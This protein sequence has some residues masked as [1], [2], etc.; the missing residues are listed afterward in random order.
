MTYNQRRRYA[1][2]TI[3][4]AELPNPNPNPNPSS[5][6]R[7]DKYETPGN[8]DASNT[9]AINNVNITSTSI[10]AA[11]N[12]NSTITNPSADR[13]SNPP[14][15]NSNPPPPPPSPNPNPNPNPNPTS[16]EK[17]IVQATR[18][19]L[20][21]VIDSV[22]LALSKR[23]RDEKGG[24]RV[25]VE[26]N[27]DDGLDNNS[28]G[29]GRDSRGKSGV[30]EF[31]NEAEE[32]FILTFEDANGKDLIYFNIVEQGDN[33][34]AKPKEVVVAFKSV[35]VATEYVE[36]LRQK[37][38]GESFPNNGKIKSLPPKTLLKI[39]QQNG[40]FVTLEE[41]I[42]GE[43]P[44]LV[45]PPRRPNTLANRLKAIWNEK[46]PERRL[47]LISLEGVHPDDVRASV[48]AIVI[49]PPKSGNGRR[50]RRPKWRGGS[51]D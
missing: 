39:C 28:D 9:N 1:S 21:S 31:W 27:G 32:V 4:L 18:K 44:P 7:D 22:K 43:L 5:E 34:G 46:D 51:D 45:E 25:G 19:V 48:A 41:K 17:Q 15:S 20:S 12:T 14:N 47:R 26:K 37:E 10:H 36:K 29:S 35:E 49:P 8:S 24:E 30:F 50:R 40:M 23:M 33:K 2:P 6:P 38:G 13:I 3:L 11:G 16:L 42:D